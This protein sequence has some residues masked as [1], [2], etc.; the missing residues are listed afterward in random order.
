MLKFNPHIRWDVLDFTRRICGPPGQLGALTTTYYCDRCR[1]LLLSDGAWYVCSV[2]SNS[3]CP[4]TTG[5]VETFFN[6]MRLTTH[7]S[8]VKFLLGKEKKSSSG[9]E[10]TYGVIESIRN[11]IKEDICEGTD[12]DGRCLEECFQRHGGTRA[13]SRGQ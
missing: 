10:A 2:I 8:D 13:S 4:M 11:F 5:E 1:S 6:T 7:I 3:A 9:A 12:V